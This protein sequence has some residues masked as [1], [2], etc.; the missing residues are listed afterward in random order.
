MMD[1][2]VFFRKMLNQV[3]LLMGM[4]LLLLIYKGGAD[5]ETHYH[6]IYFFFVLRFLQN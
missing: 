6:Y 3:F 4:Y 5:K 2:W 1:S